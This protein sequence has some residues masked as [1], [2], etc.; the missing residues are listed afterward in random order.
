MTK[1]NINEALASANT[2]ARQTCTRTFVTSTSTKQVIH[3][4]CTSG[5]LKSSGDV[6]VEVIDRENSKGSMVMTSGGGRGGSI[7]MEWTSKWL[8]AECGDVGQKK[9]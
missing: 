1:D 8:G 2:S 7:K 5:A 6:Q 9:N 3:T 4:E